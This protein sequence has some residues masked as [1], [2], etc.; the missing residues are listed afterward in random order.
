MLVIE[1]VVQLHVSMNLALRV[2]VSQ[3][4]HDLSEDHTTLVFANSHVWQLLHNMVERHTYA[5]LHY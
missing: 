2:H 4:Q 1:Q 3:C 5:E